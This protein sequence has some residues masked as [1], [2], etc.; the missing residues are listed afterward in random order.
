MKLLTANLG[1]KLLSL[2]LAVAIW[3]GVASEPEM[4]TI[5]SVP[6]EYKDSPADLDISSRIVDSV[7]LE[8]RG[9]SGRL[10]EIRASKLAV[11]LDFSKV[12]YPG[13]RTFTIGHANTNLPRGVRLVRAIPAQLRFDFEHRA[14]RSVPVLIRFSGKLPS[15]L[16]LGDV[17]AVPDT[18]RIVG[19]ETRVNRVT[20]VATD[21]VYLGSVTKDGDFRVS[22]FVDEPQVRFFD[23]PE[24]TLKFHVAKSGTLK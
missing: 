3:L 5:V 1:W 7:N 24:V 12:L 17:R 13:E 4:S 21:P 16:R 2:A 14:T 22:A 9:P 11:I 6:V 8:T 20:S 23:S 19:P 15:G 10:A 18:L